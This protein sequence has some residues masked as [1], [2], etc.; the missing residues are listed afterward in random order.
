[1]TIGT[2]LQ[3]ST[4]LAD[5]FP[6]PSDSYSGGAVTMHFRLFLGRNTLAFVLYFHQNIAVRAAKTH[7]RD[8][9]S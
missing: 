7:A 1:M 8:R 5:S 4:Q 2:N 9:A 3:V 6:H